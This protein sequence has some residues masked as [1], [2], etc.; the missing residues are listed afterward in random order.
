MQ[1]LS[2]YTDVLASNITQPSLARK[3]PSSRQKANET[4]IT[5][6]HPQFVLS[7]SQVFSDT[8]HDLKSAYCS[9]DVMT[10]QK[11]L[12]LCTSAHEK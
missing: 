4:L 7:S 12:L 9:V 10:A 11:F 8:D 6:I 1:L 3:F 5:P 2:E